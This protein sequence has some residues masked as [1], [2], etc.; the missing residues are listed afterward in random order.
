MRTKTWLTTG[1]LAVSCFIGGS[2]W[3][4]KILPN[5]SSDPKREAPANAATPNCTTEERMKE[6]AEENTFA[7]NTLGE[8][9]DIG[10]NVLGAAHSIFGGVDIP[11]GEARD[12][13][14][15]AQ[16]AKQTYE[17]FTPCTPEQEMEIKRIKEQAAVQAP[18]GEDKNPAVTPPPQTEESMSERTGKFIRTLP[19][20]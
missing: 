19:S 13:Y 18:G 4:D 15:H 9:K 12:A 8:A 14:R 6:I 5:V 16:G 17:I 3:A 2:A 20:F 10:A 7:Q 1:S 11:V